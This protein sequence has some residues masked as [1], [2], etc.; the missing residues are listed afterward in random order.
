MT[1][2]VQQPSSSTH[3]EVLKKLAFFA[4]VTAL[5]ILVL[6]GVFVAMNWHLFGGKDPCLVATEELM[7]SDN[8]RPEDFEHLIREYEK[9]EKVGTAAGYFLE[10]D[11]LS[12]RITPTEERD[13]WLEVVVYLADRGEERALRR[14][15]HVSVR[16]EATESNVSTLKNELIIHRKQSLREAWNVLRCRPHHFDGSWIQIVFEN[17]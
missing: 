8:P 1:P 11:A 10:G 5:G 15:E 13:A 4:S 6:V 9:C 3:G 16:H 14:L 12:G 7:S 17:P 2:E